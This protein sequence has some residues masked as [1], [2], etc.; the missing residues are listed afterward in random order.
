MKYLDLN[1]NLDNLI[2]DKI[3]ELRERVDNL[4]VKTEITYS[5]KNSNNTMLNIQIETK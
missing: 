3:K 1:L 2:P 5:V 4:I